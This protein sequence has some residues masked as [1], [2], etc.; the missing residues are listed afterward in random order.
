M[1]CSSICL[2]HCICSL[3]TV[4]IRASLTSVNNIFI[5]GNWIAEINAPELNLDYRGVYR[6]QERQVRVTYSYNFDR[7]QVKAARRRATGSSEEQQ[8]IHQ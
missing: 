6:F 4:Q 3:L 7:N 8:R 2:S 5:G 1:S